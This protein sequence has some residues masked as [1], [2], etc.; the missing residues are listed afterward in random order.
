MPQN[1]IFHFFVAFPNNFYLSIFRSNDSFLLDRLEPS[2][3]RIRTKPQYRL[4]RGLVRMRCRLTWAQRGPEFVQLPKTLFSSIWW[5]WPVFRLRTFHI[6]F[7]ASFTIMRS[8][9]KWKILAGHWTI[10][11]GRQNGR[12]RTLEA[13]VAAPFIWQVW[14]S[15][16]L[17]ECSYCAWLKWSALNNNG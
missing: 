2:L 15:S 9:W 10:K 7:A 11:L 14:L 16:D 5:P 4:Y 13:F 12:L 17:P 1:R 6:N 3:R 8:S